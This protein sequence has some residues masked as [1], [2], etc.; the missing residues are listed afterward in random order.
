MRKV[1]TA[2]Q[3]EQLIG[4][5]QATGERV[6]VVAK[7]QGVSASAAYLWLKEKRRHRLGARL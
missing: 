7:R 4:E 6:S 3:R 1:Y 2:E 5:V